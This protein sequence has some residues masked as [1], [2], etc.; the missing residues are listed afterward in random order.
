M[1]DPAALRR[2]VWEAE[3]TGDPQIL[4]GVCRTHQD[5][6]LLHF[7]DW[8]QL[9]PELRAAPAEAERY[10]RTM[11]RVAELFDQRL[12]RPE[13]MRRL[14]GDDGSNPLARWQ[15][16]L[17]EAQSAMQQLQFAETASL[18]TDL[19]IDVRGLKGSGVAAYLP[20]TY[21][22]LGE[23]YFQAGRAEKALEPTRTAFDLCGKQA[24]AEG[25]AAYL[26]NLYEIHRYLGQS[27]EAAACAE[28]L[29]DA[30]AQQGQADEAV[31]YRQQEQ[32]VRAGEPLNRV[33][34]GVD[35]KR[36]ELDDVLAGGVAGRV[37]FAFERNRLTLKPCQALTA[38][39]QKQGAAGRFD[40]ALNLFRAA[41]DAD[42]FAP[43]PHYEA[44]LTLLYLQRYAEAVESYETTEQ[45]APGWFHCR[46][47]L[48]LAQQLWLG[49]VPQEVFMICHALED[50]PGSPLEKVRLARKGL[51]QCPDL[52]L[53]H[54]G[55][56]KNLRAQQQ[57]KEAA[58]AYRVGL[59]CAE[60]PDVRTRLLVDLAAVIESVD[61]RHDLLNEAV[62]LNGNLVAATTAALVLASEE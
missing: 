10:V 20:V 7:A 15:K 58:A 43:Q 56:G 3:A 55:L 36:M 39:G 53:L 48:W 35:G 40:A 9:A 25:V 18:L 31:R 24:D 27:T 22:Y 41:A 34:L 17:E 60:E 12:G 23:C 51:A 4:E 1:S 61:E 44:G 13:L 54:L 57:G 33:V 11:I 2:L 26:G 5:A 29:A 47:D 49:Q 37:Q 59:D 28:Q 16:K 8:Q 52:A 32:R 46:A 21:G 45:L 50:G 62:A 38:H 42:R 6:I 30:L 14:H 19:L